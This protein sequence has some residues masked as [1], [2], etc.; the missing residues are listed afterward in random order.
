MFRQ[1]GDSVTSVIKADSRPDD[2]GRQDNQLGF[3]Q[4]GEFFGHHQQEGK[5]ENRNV[6]HNNPV[7]REINRLFSTPARQCNALSIAVVASTVSR[8]ICG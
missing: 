6:E 5:Y 7:S 2:P 4:M 1:M 3:A 8:S